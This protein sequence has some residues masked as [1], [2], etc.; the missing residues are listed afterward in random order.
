[1]RVY[2]RRLGVLYGVMT[3]AAQVRASFK[4]IVASEPPVVM[5][6]AHD[7]LSAR[8]VEAAGF[9][10]T[11][12]GSYATSAAA[13]GLPDVGALTL[14]EL[15]EH[16]QRVS[17]AV[18][19]PVLA[20]AEAGFFDAA[21]V[22]RTVQA[23]EEAGVCGV[24]IEDH[25]GGKHTSLGTALRPLD[26]ALAV[27][28]AALAA[29]TDPD[30]QVIGRTDA[31]WATGDL[32]EGLRRVQAFAE[33]GVDMVFPTGIAP[34]QLSLVRAEIPCPVMVLGD[35]PASSVRAMADAG[36]DVI[37]YYSFTLSAATRGVDRALQRLRETGDV[38][39]LVAELEDA[40]T[41]EARLGYDEYVDRAHRYG[42]QRR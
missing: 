16:A 27:L 42:D 18:S 2:L 40:P 32:D 34:E 7:P 17:R 31:V 13:H 8:I 30:F 20:D 5:P 41:L 26:E 21:N 36:A 23:F 24:H 25:A 38:R 4:R 19:V 10:G 29:R 39:E 33:A 14:T 37:V 12:I 6:G 22:W 28:R 35:L 11:Y 9:S 3:T 1:M 15:A